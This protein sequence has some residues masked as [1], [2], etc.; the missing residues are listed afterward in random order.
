MAKWVYLSIYAA[1]N[2]VIAAVTATP[3]QIH[4]AFGSSSAEKQLVVA[5]F[6]PQWRATC[7][8]VVGPGRQH[9]VL[10]G[11]RGLE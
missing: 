6:T 7:V 1:I 5:W 2:Q 8:E 11:R 9:V 3:E 10:W 4:L